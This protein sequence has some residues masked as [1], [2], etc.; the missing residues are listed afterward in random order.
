MGEAV[1]E[2]ST[3]STP[4]AGPALRVEVLSVSATPDETAAWKRVHHASI[5]G[6][7]RPV[8]GA[9][10]NRASPY[11]CIPPLGGPTS[12]LRCAD[13]ALARARSAHAF[14]GPAGARGACRWGRGDC[15]LRRM[16]RCV[17]AAPS[18]CAGCALTRRC[19]A[20]Q[21]RTA[22]T[23]PVG[24]P[25]TGLSVVV[26]ETLRLCVRPPQTPTSKR[27]RAHAPARCAVPGRARRTGVRR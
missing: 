6:A 4:F 8:A 11:N 26:G 9:V 5:T 15:T 18:D 7:R 10:S 20:P 12:V 27:A 1:E 24:N 23:P 19:R 22:A 21:E 13:G 2:P 3:P 17:P 25:S 14:G 16:L